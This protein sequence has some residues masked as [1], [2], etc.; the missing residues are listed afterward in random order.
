[1][2]HWPCECGGRFSFDPPMVHGK[3][4]FCK[5]CRR[6][7]ELQEIADDLIRVQQLYWDPGRDPSRKEAAKGDT[8]GGGPV[9]GSPPSTGSPRL[10]RFAGLAAFGIVVAALMLGFGRNAPAPFV[11][12][13]E[14]GDEVEML[15]EGRDVYV[16]TIASWCGGSRLFVETVLLPVSREIGSGADRPLICLVFSDDEWPSA[17]RFLSTQEQVDRARASARSV[18]PGLGER[19]YDPRWVVE[20]VVNSDMLLCRFKTWNDQDAQPGA[21][22]LF[23]SAEDASWKDIV[24]EDMFY[25]DIQ[26][27][28]DRY[29]PEALGRF[30]RELAR[31]QRSQELRLREEFDRDPFFN[32]FM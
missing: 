17:E 21:Y 16:F 25:P 32:G 3:T 28:V 9:P 31:K 10:R 6:V 1:M 5:K 13:N 11:L 15:A 14:F 12:E 4:A 23:Y 7:Y 8:K 29:D 18:D 20:H 2:N 30:A 27:L 19:F 26:E 24:H 22:P